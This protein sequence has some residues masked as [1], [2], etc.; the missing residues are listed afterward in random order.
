M[1]GLPWLRGRI[2]VPRHA[3]S[4][5]DSPSNPSSELN[6]RLDDGRVVAALEEYV[7]LLRGGWRPDRAEFLARHHSID[8][9]LSDRL[10]D[11]EFV[12][13]AMSPLAETGPL[14]GASVDSLARRGG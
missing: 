8:G 6:S 10:E 5:A 1:P 13:R 12:Q 11:L 7:Q 4:C 9:V 2:M 3:S 14:G